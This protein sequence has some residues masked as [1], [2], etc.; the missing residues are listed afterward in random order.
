M[1]LASA[2]RSPS[3][4]PRPAFDRRRRARTPR[5]DRRRSSRPRGSS[6]SAGARRLRPPPRHAARRSRRPLRPRRADRGEHFLRRRADHGAGAEHRGHARGCQEVVVLRRNDAADDDQ[7]VVR[8]PAPAA[9]RSSCGTS[10]LWPAASVETPTTWTSF[11]IA[12]RAASSGRLEQRPDV[13]VEA[14]IGEARWRSPWRRGRGRPGPS[15]ATI[16]RGRRPSSSAKR[17]MSA[18]APAHAPSFSNAAP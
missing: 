18:A 11:S 2:R 17:A 12:W 13:D 6:A 4:R 7:D 16:S 9:P 15:F 10:V 5:R 1:A 3:V 14:Q 8:R